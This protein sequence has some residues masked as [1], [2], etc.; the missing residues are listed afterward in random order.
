[1]EMS[2]ST[3]VEVV[4]VTSVVNC[5][6]REAEVAVAVVLTVSVVVTVAE[7]IL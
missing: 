3:E 5:V 7:G 6:V 2:V 1:M 4:S